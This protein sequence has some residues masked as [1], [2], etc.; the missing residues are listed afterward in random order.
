MGFSIPIKAIQIDEGKI[1]SELNDSK[2][3]KSFDNNVPHTS[4]LKSDAPTKFG[5]YLRNTKTLRNKNL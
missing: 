2:N 1:Q 3:N 4:D 5:S